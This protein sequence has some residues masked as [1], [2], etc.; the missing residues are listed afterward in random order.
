MQNGTLLTPSPDPFANAL[1]ILNGDAASGAFG[2][3]N[4]LL[5]NTVVTCLANRYS[6]P[7]NFFNLRLAARVCFFCNLALKRRCLWRT[8]LTSPLLSGRG[9]QLWAETWRIG[10]VVWRT[11]NLAAWRH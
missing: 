4:D 5:G 8:P 9:N 10:T 6:L 3:F 11:P 2:V 7:D 1:E